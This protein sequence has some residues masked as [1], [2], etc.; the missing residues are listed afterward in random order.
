MKMKRSY[1]WALLAMALVLA[2]QT[3]QAADIFWWLRR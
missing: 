1:L 2:P 3:A